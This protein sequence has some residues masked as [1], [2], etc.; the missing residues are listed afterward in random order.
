MCYLIIHLYLNKYFLCL[1]VV[2]HLKNGKKFRNISDLEISDYYDKKDFISLIKDGN[3]FGKI[4]AIHHE[5]ACS[6]TLE[7]DGQ[8]M[9]ENNYEYSKVLLHYC[10]DRK[11]TFFYA[12]SAAAY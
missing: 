2:D 11:I 3:D 4:D 7:W 9:M 8:Y 10:L 5:G 12:S 6:D 1:L